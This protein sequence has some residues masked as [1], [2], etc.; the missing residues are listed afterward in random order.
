MVDYQLDDD[1]KSLPMGNGCLTVSIHLKLIVSGT[2]YSNFPT[3]LIGSWFEPRNSLWP[4]SGGQVTHSRVKW[5][6]T[7][8]LKVHFESPGSD[9]LI[10]IV[11]L[12][13][14]WPE[15]PKQV[16]QLQ[17]K[18]LQLPNRSIPQQPTP[19]LPF[20]VATKICLSPWLP[21]N[22]DGIPPNNENKIKKTPFTNG[23]RTETSPLVQVLLQLWTIVLQLRERRWPILHVSSRL[24]CKSQDTQQANHHGEVAKNGCRCQWNCTCQRC[25]WV[26]WLLPISTAVKTLGGTLNSLP[27]NHHNDSKA[28]HT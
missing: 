20:F 6:P 5:P 9:Y 2:R 1:S 3:K 12:S 4:F 21:P 26:G 15:T 14:L 18:V 11:H 17:H 23:L 25:W 22:L 19:A 8:G 16:W 10:C 7:R 28:S 27:Q 24:P 13:C